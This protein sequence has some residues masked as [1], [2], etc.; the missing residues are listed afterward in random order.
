MHSGTPPSRRDA[1][2]AL[3]GVCQIAALRLQS[4]GDEGQIQDVAELV[5]ARSRTYS[6]WES[7]A[8]PIEGVTH[9]LAIPPLPGDEGW[10]DREYEVIEELQLKP[11]GKDGS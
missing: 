5:K 9:W 10:G 2:A 6:D 11:L 3:D 8:E 4:G 1:E 7:R